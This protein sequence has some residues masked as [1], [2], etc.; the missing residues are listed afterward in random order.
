MGHRRTSLRS[1]LIAAAIALACVR[2][3]PAQAPAT[4]P[5]QADSLVESLPPGCDAVAVITGASRQRRSPAGRGLQAMIDESA[6]FAETTA[7]WRQLAQAMGWPTDRAFDELLGRRV[8]VVLRGLDSARPDWAVLTVV[9]IEAERRMRDT[10]RAAPRG[11]IGGMPVLA[12]EDGKYELVIGRL[13]GS[14]V[15]PSLLGADAA[16]SMVLLVPSGDGSLMAALAP[17]LLSRTGLAGPAPRWTP[18]GRECDLALVLRQ[19]AHTPAAGPWSGSR[20][21]CLTAMQTGSGWDAKLVC[22]PGL[23][24]DRASGPAGPRPWADGAFN[25]LQRDALVAIM[26][27]PGASPLRIAGLV[28][29]LEGLLPALPFPVGHPSGQLTGIFV[30]P[31]DPTPRTSPPQRAEPRL[32]SGDTPPARASTTSAGL[33]S[34]TVAVQVA[35]GHAVAAEGD[36]AVARFIGIL[37][38]GQDDSGAEPPAVYREGIIPEQTVRSL[39]LDGSFPIHET[40]GRIL[41]QSFG[42][43]PVLT[44]GASPPGPAIARSGSRAEPAPGWWVASLLPSS[45]A[46]KDPVSRDARALSTDSGVIRPRLSIGVIRPAAIDR[47]ARSAE[48]GLLGSLGALRWIDS[49]GWDAWLRADGAVEGTLTIR[50]AR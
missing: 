41:E 1:A 48:P 43:E 16:G 36:S 22:S 4:P 19:P 12:V 10:L 47:S 42:Q 20:F 8:A 31:T 18:G 28:P 15:D 6:A 27:I 35:D 13:P 44:W 14:A 3:A 9:S 7:A 5:S 33:L 40:F 34:V 30:R 46:G 2:P 17:M 39:T 37:Q 38:S 29:G 50:M 23:I 32:A 45:A 26:G 21:L 49:L 24:W 25:T 11:S